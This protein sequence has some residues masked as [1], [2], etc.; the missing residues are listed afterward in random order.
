MIQILGA[1]T[2]ASQDLRGR[3]LAL[4]LLLR[5][6]SPGPRGLPLPR[7]S[8]RGDCCRGAPP[9]PAPHGTPPPPPRRLGDAPGLPAHER[10]SHGHPNDQ[11]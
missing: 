8:A 7:A 1:R 5:G 4:R 10:N 9:T 3:K 2:N 6:V 11:D